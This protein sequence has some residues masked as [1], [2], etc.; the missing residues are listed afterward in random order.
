MEDGVRQSSPTPRL[1]IELL[2]QCVDGRCHTE[3]ICTRGSC[4]ALVSAMPVPIAPSKSMHSML[5][6]VL[7]LFNHNYETG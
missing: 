5:R 7:A 1:P 3:D 4:M 6:H 2:S